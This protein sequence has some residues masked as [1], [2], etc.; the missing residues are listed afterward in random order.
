MIAPPLSHVPQSGIIHILSPEST[1]NTTLY[2]AP[3][4][5]KMNDDGFPCRQLR[6]CH[7]CHPGL[8]DAVDLIPM[9]FVL[10]DGTVQ[11]VHHR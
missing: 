2:C 1:A 10:G 7:C 5:L 11:R 6:S 9:V 3:R 4:C 8:D